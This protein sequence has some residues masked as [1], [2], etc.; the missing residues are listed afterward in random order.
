MICI[1]FD[2]RKYLY[3]LVVSSF[4]FFVLYSFQITD[5]LNSLLRGLD[6]F[7]MSLADI[8]GTGTCNFVSLIVKIILLALSLLLVSF[9]L[10]ATDKSQYFFHLSFNS[11]LK[12]INGISSDFQKL[13]R[14]I[15][16]T[17]DVEFF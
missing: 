7:L 9:L 14:Y 10:T 12:L 3:S 5:Y 15:N 11:T 4:S 6:N 16:G 1:N 17:A 8:V 2:L 13:L